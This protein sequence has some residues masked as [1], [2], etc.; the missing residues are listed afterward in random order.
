MYK[1]YPFEKIK[2]E[3]K[4]NLN[5]KRY[6][7]VIEVAKAAQKL[8][9]IYNINQN[10]AL[11]AALLH[12]YAKDMD[13]EKITYYVK[14]YD[15][16]FDELELESSELMHGRIAKYIAFFEYN[17]WDTD[18]LNAVEFHT[19]GRKD[20]SFFEI[21]ISLSDYIEEGRDFHRADEIRM[22]ANINPLEA[23]LMAMDGTIMH[24]IE[25]GKKIH[26]R[27]IEARNY[28]IYIKSNNEVNKI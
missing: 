2:I 7:H 16:K 18:I 8:A 11:V 9:A 1:N 19:T 21:I 23:L 17:I 3:L 15:I 25:K 24:L 6:K 14:R 20:M 26:P 22:M 27:S 13:S 28:L 12:D 4:K 10:K 5:D